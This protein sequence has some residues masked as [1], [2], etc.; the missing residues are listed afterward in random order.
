MADTL[1]RYLVQSQRELGTA[2]ILEGVDIHSK[3]SL[4]ELV[5]D[6][7]V[8]LIQGH[9]LS[10]AVSS[11]DAQWEAQVCAKIKSNLGWSAAAQVVDTD[12]AVLH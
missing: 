3:L 2:V 8:G 7:G 11:F 5:S 9:S 1:I 4:N 10:K 6:I 12:G